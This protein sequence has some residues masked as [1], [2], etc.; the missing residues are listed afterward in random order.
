MK[1]IYKKVIFFHIFL[2]SKTLAILDKNFLD[3]NYFT[4]A[5]MF[6]A[7]FFVNE[8]PNYVFNFFV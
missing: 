3:T 1:K 7:I 2:S 4:Q 8:K 6:L 5:R